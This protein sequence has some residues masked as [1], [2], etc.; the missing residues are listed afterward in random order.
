MNDPGS[1]LI[2]EATAWLRVLASQAITAARSDGSVT[3]SSP[4]PELAQARVPGPLDELWRRRR[5]ASALSFVWP[6]LEPVIIAG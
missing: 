1:H 4:S 5:G 6:R 2:P 3:A